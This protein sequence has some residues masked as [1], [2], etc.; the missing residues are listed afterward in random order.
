MNWLGEF[1]KTGR[2]ECMPAV[3]ELDA[4]IRGRLIYRIGLGE[5]ATEGQF[6]FAGWVVSWCIYEDQIGPL[7]LVGM[8]E[9]P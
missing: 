1:L 3:K 8:M 6:I 5:Q 9:G 2:I 4:R 7:L